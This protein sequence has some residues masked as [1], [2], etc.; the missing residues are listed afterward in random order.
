MFHDEKRESCILLLF[1]FFLAVY[2]LKFDWAPSIII[3]IFA[4][5]YRKKTLLKRVV[6]NEENDSRER[7]SAKNPTT[8]NNSNIKN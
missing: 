3:Y 6:N 1:W 2:S 4:R 5:I 7:E 8:I